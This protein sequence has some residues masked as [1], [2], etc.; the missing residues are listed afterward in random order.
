VRMV[1]GGGA[2][3]VSEKLLSSI[4]IWPLRGDL[5]RARFTCGN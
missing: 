4:L 1:G 3:M 5:G 2:Q